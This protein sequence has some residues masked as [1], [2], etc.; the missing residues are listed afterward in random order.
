MYTMSET[1]AKSD[2]DSKGRSVYSCPKFEQFI[3]VEGDLA[4]EG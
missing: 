4:F 3:E 1:R 2:C